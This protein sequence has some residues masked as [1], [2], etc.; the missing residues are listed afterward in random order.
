MNTLK[1]QRQSVLEAIYKLSD[2]TAEM[3][4]PLDSIYPDMR[5]NQDDLL[6]ALLSLESRKYVEITK[7]FNL[8]PVIVM[9]T[10]Q[11]RI[12][13]EDGEPEQMPASQH[14]YFN[15]PTNFQQGNHNVQN[16]QIG[17]TLD[18]VGEL[19]DAL[20]ENGHDELAEQID[21][22]V[23]QSNNPANL[24]TYF[25]QLITAVAG[26]GA[27]PVAEALISIFTG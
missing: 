16:I 22:E 13:A 24:K 6:N 7:D 27:G 14:N 2:G 1:A 4:V 12:V 5:M 21:R 10:N 26:G 25:G 18:Q 11:G 19:V 20:R 17:F 15:G 3:A 23:V 9:M 8:E